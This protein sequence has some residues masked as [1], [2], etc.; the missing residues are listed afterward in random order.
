MVISSRKL[1]NVENAVKQLKSKGFNDVHGVVCHVGNK[2]DRK[3]LFEEAVSKFS[4]ID[5]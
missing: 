2:E 3:N 1:A 5:V 4:G